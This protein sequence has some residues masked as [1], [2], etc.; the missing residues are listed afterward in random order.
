MWPAY[1]AG[2]VICVSSLLSVLASFPGFF[3]GF[4]FFGFPPSAK[5]KKK[6]KTSPN[7]NSTDEIEDLHENHAAKADVASSV[8]KTNVKLQS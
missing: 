4:T 8:N 5:K 3:S 1:D 2:P 6:T 7:P